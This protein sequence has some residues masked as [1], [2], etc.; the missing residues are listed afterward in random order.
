MLPSPTEAA[1]LALGPLFVGLLGG[2]ALFLFGMEQLTAGLRAA[3]GDRLRFL[4]EKLTRTRWHAALT[5]AFSTAVLQSSSLTSVMVVGFVSAGLIGLPQAIGFM[6]GAKVGT[7]LTAQIVAFRITDLG[8]LAVAV[9]FGLGWLAKGEGWRRAGKILMG[10]GLLFF[11]MKLMGDATSPLRA[12]EPFVR[13]MQELENPLLGVFVGALVT[14]V[15]QSSSATTGLVIVFAGQG[16]VGLESAIAIALGANVG[17]CAT[18]ALASLKGTREAKQAALAHVIF[19]SLGA[20]LWVGF[21][22]RL[23]DLARFLSPTRPDLDGAARVAA[24]APRQIANAHTLFN[25]ANLLLFIGATGLLASLAQ[26]IVPSRRR[27]QEDAAPRYLDPLYLQTPAVALGLAARELSHLGELAT[28][29]LRKGLLAACEGAEQDL[30]EVQHLEDS[31]DRLHEEI[32]LYLGRLSAHTSTEAE[33]RRVAELLAL[34]NYLESLGDTLDLQLIPLGR[35]RL[36]RRVRIGGATLSLLHILIAE[37]EATLADALLAHAQGDPEPAR[38]ARERKSAFL[39]QQARAR[40]VIAKSLAPG[41]AAAVQAF[42]IESDL[43]E[44]MRRVFDLCRR[45]ARVI[46]EASDSS[47]RERGSGSAETPP[48]EPLPLSA[49]AADPV[50]AKE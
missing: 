21:I 32:V 36:A 6:L 48:A 45:L 31:M 28:R 20:A 47:E 40:E 27:E 29:A 7:T 3:A 41:N 34:A 18:T 26:R 33:G 24:E 50:E 49:A 35:Q 5:G 9:G 1:D 39:Q 16:L 22:G 8:L 25:L 15:I 17:T 38:R 44:Q 37:I 23:A 19:N 13:W 4:L 14:A 46:V 11:G 43:V 12:H 10:L 2:L 30:D 42:R